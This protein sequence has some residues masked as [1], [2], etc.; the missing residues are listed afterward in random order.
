[1]NGE[2]EVEEVTR[3]FLHSRVVFA[4]IPLKFSVCQVPQNNY[5]KM[6]FE[7]GP[8]H[9]RPHHVPKRHIPWVKLPCSFCLAHRK[10]WYTQSLV[11]ANSLI[12]HTVPPSTAIDKRANRVCLDIQSVVWYVPAKTLTFLVHAEKLL[13]DGSDL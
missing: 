13:A 8:S 12:A 11:C 2:E 7:K 9:V 3:V 6:I 10:S 1:M 4:A 5:S